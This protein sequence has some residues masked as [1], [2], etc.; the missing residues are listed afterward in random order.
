MIYLKFSF[1]SSGKDER[2]THASDKYASL[3]RPCGTARQVQHH[4]G[5]REKKCATHCSTT[6]PPSWTPASSDSIHV[7][8]TNN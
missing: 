6:N 1:C 4:G 5:I 7:A 3:D 8:K 2:H